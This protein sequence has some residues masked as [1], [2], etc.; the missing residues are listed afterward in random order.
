MVSEV[1]GSIPAFNKK[2]VLRTLLIKIWLK[3][4]VLVVKWLA[5]L[6]RD[7]ELLRSIP[8]LIS[9]FHNF[10]SSI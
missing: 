4:V 9:Q 1:T 2:L 6:V 7:L 3:R 10:S 5:E 8:V